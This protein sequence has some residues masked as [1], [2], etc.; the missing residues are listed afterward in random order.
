[1]SMSCCVIH[2]VSHERGSNDALSG[3]YVVR[4]MFHRIDST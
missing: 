2:I 3:A 4:A 1:M